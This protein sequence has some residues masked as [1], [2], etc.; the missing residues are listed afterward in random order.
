MSSTF[1][2]FNTAVSGLMAAQR[3]LDATGQNVVNANTPG[4]SR[5]RVG[6]ATSGPAV[7]ATFHTGRAGSY[8][9]VTVTDVTRVRD[10]FME[11]TRAAAG[12]R[13]SALTAQAAALAG[14][15]RL[16]SEPGDSGLQQTLD[17]FYAGWHDLAGHA[18]DPSG[19]GSVVIQRGVAVAEQLRAV[20]NGLSREWT[21]S[22]ANLAD[23]VSQ[24]NQAASDLAGLN[25][26]IRAGSV[27]GTAVN[28]L[29]DS[30]DLLVRRLGELVGAQAFAGEDGQLTVSVNGIAIVSGSTAQTLTLTGGT[31]VSTATADPPTV[32]WGTT[33]VPVDSGAA[34][35][36]LAAL[37]S[38]L[39]GLK[40][41]LDGVATVLRDAVNGVHAQ[42]YNRAGNTGLDFF[43]GTGAGDLEVAVSDPLQLALSATAGTVDGSVA[44]RI[45][46]LADD[47]TASTVLGGPGPSARWRQ[48][49]STLGVQL[50]SLK[51]AGT[52]QEG[53][54][55]AAEDAVQSSAGVNLDEEMSNMLLFQRAYQASAR[56]LTTVDEMLDTLI[57]RTGM[58]GR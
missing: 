10:A 48:L 27:G 55:A 22:R 17:Q 15:E 53:V 37:R 2:S 25:A 45:G 38:D 23:V 57:N 16:L 40:D 29:A 1:T 42:G 21:N 41:R 9:G 24:V 54:V 56:V 3:A 20:S 5:Q 19:A 28:E 14:A 6:L 52:V 18:D 44:R 58:V 7:S 36:H 11:A 39:P 43:T 8:G 12:S 13:Q 4:Y 51:A 35:G 34:A 32:R 47:F 33:A 31:D 26:K 50:Q 49:T 46:D 30:R